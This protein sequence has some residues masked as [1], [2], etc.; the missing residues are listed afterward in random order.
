MTAKLCI[1]NK[2]AHD[3]PGG[4]VILINGLYVRRKRICNLVLLLDLWA[5]ES[6]SIIE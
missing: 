3:L 5:E 1:M 6:S 4:R 2:F